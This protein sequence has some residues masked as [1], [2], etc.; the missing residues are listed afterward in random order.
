MYKFYIIC[1]FLLCKTTHVY[2]FFMNIRK[3]RVRGNTPFGSVTGDAAEIHNSPL[4]LVGGLGGSRLLLNN[5]NIWPPTAYDYFLNYETWKNNIINNK[6]VT[7][8]EL[9]NSES[10]DL[11]SVVPFLVSRNYFDEII[12]KNNTHAIPYDFRRIDDK[13]YLNSFYT[14]LENYIES[15]NEPIILITHSTGGILLHWFLYNQSQEWKDIHIKLVINVNVPFGGLIITL[16][17]CF[18]YSIV[19]FFIGIELL[20]NLGGFIINMP[21]PKFI[22]PILCVN[23]DQYDDFFSYFNL[24]EVEKRYKI[25]KDMIDS[26]DKS[27]NVKTCIVYSSD[28][29]TPSCL[30][31]EELHSKNTLLEHFI[32]ES[33]KSG[34]KFRPKLKVIYG[35]GDGI[36]P[37]QSLLVPKHWIQKNIKY[38]NIKNH[39]HSDVLFS[40][41]LKD[42]INE[43][44]YT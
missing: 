23:G 20:R 39:G 32:G 15:F 5:Q 36:V 24:T 34:Y 13:E 4:L 1:Y 44:L 40:K 21:N 2:S 8:L 35:Y 3:S 6:N 42:I 43:N 14:K 11:H 17:D 10:L 37:L 19:N 30:S 25:N 38:Y 33:R 16:H 22:K 31:V 18:K 29:K 26:F 28:Q 9:G 7:T 41:E 12:K 27:T